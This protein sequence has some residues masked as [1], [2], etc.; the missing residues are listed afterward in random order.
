MWSLLTFPALCFA[1]F[2]ILCSISMYLYTVLWLLYP[3]SSEPF[4]VS[5]ILSAILLP[6]FP[7]LAKPSQT[8]QASHSKESNRDFLNHCATREESACQCRGPR[9]EPWSK[10]IPHV[11]GQLSLCATTTEAHTPRARAPQQEKPPQ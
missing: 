1:T 5:S 8:A 6:A 10:K 11:Q 7:D 4:H 2:H 3:L 9:F